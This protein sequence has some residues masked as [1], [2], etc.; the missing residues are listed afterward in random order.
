[1]SANY[2][3]RL[4][5]INQGNT[6]Q[7]GTAQTAKINL[8]GLC[9][10]PLAHI[11][12][13]TTPAPIVDADTTAAPFDQEWHA[14]RAAIYEFDAGFSRQEAERRAYLEVTKWVH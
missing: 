1:M 14:E 9:S 4:R 10:S 3:T 11:Q 7:D 12:Q 6:R 13:P 2:L 8:R 5:A